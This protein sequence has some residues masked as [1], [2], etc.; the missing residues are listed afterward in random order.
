MTVTK[1]QILSAAKALGKGHTYK[2]NTAGPNTYD[3][4]GL[5]YATLVKLGLYKGARFSTRNWATVSTGIVSKVSAP[6]VGDIILWSGKH[7]GFCDATGSVY[8]ALSASRGIL[9]TSIAGLT[10][11]LGT[12]TYYRLRALAVPKP[13]PKPATAP[14]VLSFGSKGAAVKALQEL[15]NKI[16]PTMPQLATDSD[17]GY[18]TETRVK[19]FQH[20]HGLTMD[21]VV[22]KDTYAALG[23][24]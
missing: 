5:V 24:K 22:G 4:S 11:E 23:V 20:Q 12:P 17:F 1:A 8:S 15:L 7:V 18:R 2:L 9:S 16:Y 14:K 10:K 21:G 13:A 3:C 19:Y 6:Q